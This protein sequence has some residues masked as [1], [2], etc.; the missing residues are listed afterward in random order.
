[1]PTSAK[2]HKSKNGTHKKREHT[3]TE[4]D[5][6]R[7]DGKKKMGAHLGCCCG[8]GVPKGTSETALVIIVC[9]EFLWQIYHTT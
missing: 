2:K 7:K 4:K 8:G 3:K 5:G 1:V 6:N 9:G